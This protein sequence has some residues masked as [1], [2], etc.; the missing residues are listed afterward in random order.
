MQKSSHNSGPQQRAR[1]ATYLSWP[2]HPWLLHI[3]ATLPIVVQDNAVARHL[4]DHPGQQGAGGFAR[5][6]HVAAVAVMLSYA[7]WMVRRC[8][9]RRCKPY[10]TSDS[11]PPQLLT[12][13]FTPRAPSDAASRSRI[14]CRAQ[15]DAG[16]GGAGI[17]GPIKQ[18]PRP[19]AL[20]ASKRLTR[21]EMERVVVSRRK[22]QQS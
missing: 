12:T 9:G 10:L 7:I 13:A 5:R 3:T 20:P 16:C 17:D 14:A 6:R 11:T 1:A 4:Q 15:V 21:A 18:P 22:A 8:L 19:P 2:T